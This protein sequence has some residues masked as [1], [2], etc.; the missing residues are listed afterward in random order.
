[1]VLKKK[2]F[3]GIVLKIMK[4]GIKE[5]GG[6]FEIGVV[7]LLIIFCIVMLVI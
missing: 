5:N 3:F 2:R 7:V 1:M 4:I 6:G